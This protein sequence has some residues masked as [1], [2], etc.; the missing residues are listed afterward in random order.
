MEP[1]LI[2][3]SKGEDVLGVMSR[4]GMTTS[5]EVFVM[6]DSLS[7]QTIRLIVNDYRGEPRLAF[8]VA[9][10]KIFNPK[11]AASH[12]NIR[13]FGGKQVDREVFLDLVSKHYPD[14]ATWF[15]FHP[16]CF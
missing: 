16:E 6:N 10:M 9:V 5:H 4:L 7:C 15:L 12:R 13:W 8:T 2:S 14:Y 3:Y 11:I 1:I